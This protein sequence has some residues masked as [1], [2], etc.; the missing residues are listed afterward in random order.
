MHFELDSCRFPAYSFTNKETTLL[1]LLNVF[2]SAIL[3]STLKLKPK[4]KTKF[5]PRW[6]PPRCRH[7]ERRPSS[8]PAWLSEQSE[9]CPTYAPAPSP[10]NLE[11]QELGI[12]SLP[13]T[14]LPGDF[15]YFP[16]I[17]PDTSPFSGLTSDL[18]A[19]AGKICK[20]TQSLP[21]KTFW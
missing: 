12:L 10:R 3:N 8:P 21:R 9:Q 18:D 1:R 20:T 13:L 6:E 16:S 19:N 5:N 11:I 4:L 7:W 2:R 14:V 15:I 17:S